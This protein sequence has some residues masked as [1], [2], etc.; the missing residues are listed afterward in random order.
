MAC[1]A[2]TQGATLGG[3]LEVGKGVAVAAP[4]GSELCGDQARPAQSTCPA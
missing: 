4:E 3:E 2:E 1:R